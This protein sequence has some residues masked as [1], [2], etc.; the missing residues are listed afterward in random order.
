MLILHLRRQTF[1]LRHFLL[2]R[3]ILLCLLFFSVSKSVFGASFEVINSYTREVEVNFTNNSD[4]NAVDFVV[5]PIPDDVIF[6]VKDI[7]DF[8]WNKANGKMIIYGYTKNT[9]IP[10]GK[11]LTLIYNIDNNIN[12]ELKD[13]NGANSNAEYVEVKG[14]TG[15]VTLKFPYQTVVDTA[16]TIVGL[17]SEGVDIDNNN[18][19]DILDV[20]KLINRGE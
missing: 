4:V 17:S 10:N 20:Q 16:N 14:D 5:S 9:P 19:I 13:C 8:A 3:Y 18:K 1:D 7:K 12:I 6:N 2:I 15:L 11:V